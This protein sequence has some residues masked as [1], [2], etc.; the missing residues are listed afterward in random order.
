MPRVARHRPTV[1]RR[2][3]SSERVVRQSLRVDLKAEA[4]VPLDHDAVERDRSHD[5]TIAGPKTGIRIVTAEL[6][7][8]SD[9]HTGP[10]TG[11][12]MACTEGIH[13]LTVVRWWRPRIPRKRHNEAG[14][15]MSSPKPEV[16]RWLR[17]EF[18]G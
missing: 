1:V 15:I 3:G 6:D 14:V 9:S 11:G 7:F 2:S 8:R 17:T 13:T 18:D 4:L 12:K 10:K 5:S 16:R